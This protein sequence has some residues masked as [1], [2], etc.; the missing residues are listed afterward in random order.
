MS[1]TSTISAEHPKASQISIARIKNTAIFLLVFEALL[2][3]VPL[4]ILGNAINWPASLDEPASVNLPLILEQFPAMFTGYSIY[5]V[6]SLLFWPWLSLSIRGLGKQ[7]I[8]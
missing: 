8:S 2:L 4:I 7:I 3:F 1:S 6:Y 5:F